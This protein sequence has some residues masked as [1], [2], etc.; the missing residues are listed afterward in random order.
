MFFLFYASESLSPLARAL[1]EVEAVEYR[2]EN[3]PECPLL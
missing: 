3:G 2:P 1:I